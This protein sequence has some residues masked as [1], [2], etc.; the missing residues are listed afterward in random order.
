MFDDLREMVQE[1]ESYCQ[2]VVMLGSGFDARP[3]R[4]PLNAT[5]WFEVDR[6]AVILEKEKQLLK[7]DAALSFKVR[8]V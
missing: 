7:C 3:W 5:R 1:M 6:K 2:Q 8:N 4:L